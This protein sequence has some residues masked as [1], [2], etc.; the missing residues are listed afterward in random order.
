MLRKTAASALALVALAT[1]TATA[2]ATAPLDFD[3]LAIHTEA[4]ITPER[5]KA[6]KAAL[7][8]SF[9]DTR[10]TVAQNLGDHFAEE[11]QAR[12]LSLSGQEMELWASAIMGGW[13]VVH[14]GRDGISCIV[15]TGQDW[16]A[17]QDAHTLLEDTLASA[18]FAAVF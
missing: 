18:Q 2:T 15:A 11:P 5:E 7:Q 3:A 1:L 10:G 12:V 4:P 16:R 8:Q 17:D 14:H 9:C 6:E 13:T